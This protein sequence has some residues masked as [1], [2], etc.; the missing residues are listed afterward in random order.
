MNLS[1]RKETFVEQPVTYALEMNGK[2]FVIEHVRA[3]VCVET[4]EQLF[5]PD[6]VEY[7]ERTIWAD[8]PSS[9]TY[10]TEN[11]PTGELR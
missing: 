8:N 2:F 5:S 7:L 10:P 9:F 6:T 4:G 1:A 3:G 11:H